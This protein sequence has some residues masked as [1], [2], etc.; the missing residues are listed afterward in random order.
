[1]QIRRDRR[2]KG[3]ET[4]TTW[5]VCVRISKETVWLQQSKACDEA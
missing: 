4:R 2:D 1:L 5:Y 3:T